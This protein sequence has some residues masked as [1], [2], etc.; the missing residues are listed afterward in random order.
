MDKHNHIL[1]FII[2][3]THG[4]T[5]RFVIDL[6]SRLVL[7]WLRCRRA[8]WFRATGCFGL[9]LFGIPHIDCD[10]YPIAC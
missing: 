5:P 4:S 3:L 7:G 9:T 8:R 2:I 10:L 6:R 1:A